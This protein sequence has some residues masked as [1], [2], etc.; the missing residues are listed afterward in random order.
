MQENYFYING[1]KRLKFF[2][3][4][5]YNFNDPYK[6]SRDQTRHTIDELPELKIMIDH[7]QGRLLANNMIELNKTVCYYQ[8]IYLNNTAIA[9]AEQNKL[10]NRIK[11][12][13]S[14][15][16]KLFAV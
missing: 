4:S 2:H 6:I 5:Y 8:E 12:R 3:F 15:Y 10:S 9:K 14:R 7:Y 16:L 1:N 13:L 11:R